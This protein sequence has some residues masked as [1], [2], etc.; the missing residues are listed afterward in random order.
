MRSSCPFSAA[1]SLCPGGYRLTS[2]REFTR[3]NGFARI[4]RA[5]QMKG[6]SRAAL[7]TC[8]CGLQLDLDDAEQW[9]R[10][11]VVHRHRG[12]SAEAEQSWRRILGLRRPDQFSA[13]TRGF[14]VI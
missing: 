6:D 9:F 13:L 11:T 2:V 5:H 8:A 12:E 3:P 10:K 7:A 4:T 14:L 1:E